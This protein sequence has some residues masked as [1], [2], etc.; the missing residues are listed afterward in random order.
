MIRKPIELSL[1]VARAF[2][3]DMRTYFAEENAVTRY[4][5]AAR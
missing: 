5:I 3:K 2:V 1:A 4:E